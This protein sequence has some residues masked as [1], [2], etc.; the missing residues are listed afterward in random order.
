MSLLPKNSISRVLGT[1]ELSRTR[2]FLALAFA[3]VADA[4]QL[5]LGPAG[6]VLV[7]QGID[8][9]AMVAISVA[10]GFHPLFLPTF[11]AEFVPG[12]DMLPTWTGCVLFVIARRRAVQPATPPVH[13]PRSDVID[14]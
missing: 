8:F 11:V 12:L 9:V 6:W 2:M 4:V 1:R 13:P 3:V 10:I 14:V 5:F 7:D